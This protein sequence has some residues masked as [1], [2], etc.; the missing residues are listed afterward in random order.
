MLAVNGRIL[1]APNM[2]YSGNRTVEPRF[3]SWNM[4]SVK[5]SKG[6]TLTAWSVLWLQSQ[7]GRDPWG[8]DP[9][10]LL[11]TLKAFHQRL[12]DCGMQCSPPFLPGVNV[13]V[14]SRNDQLAIEEGF[15]RL[16]SKKRQEKLLLIIMP[17][18]NDDHYNTI[19]RCG[20]LEF[21]VQT[22]CVLASKFAKPNNS[23][24]FANVALKFNL[25][26]G[27]IN[28]TLPTDKLGFIAQG[29]TIVV[30]ID[31]THP[32]P[33]SESSAPSVASMVA[34]INKDLGQFPA[35]LYTQRGRQE[36]VA[37]LSIMLKTRL[38]LWRK[39]NGDRLPENILVYRDGVSEGQ[40]PAVLA[41]ELP[42][43]QQA[44]REI[45][46]A[47]SKQPAISIVIVSKRHSTRFYIT[48][49]DGNKIDER[50]SNPKHGTIVDRG[51]TEPRF[52][53]F[54]LQAHTALQGTARPA[55]Y[56]VV[57][58]EILSRMPLPHGF[59]HAADVLEDV[60]HNLSYM[61]GRATKAVSYCPAAYYADI[62][63][64]RGRCYL[65]HLFS[66]TMSEADVAESP[67]GQAGGADRGQL[68]RVHENLKDTM[69][70][71]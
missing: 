65:S 68:I 64:E 27:G 7:S 55:H 37:D 38:A 48:T 61:F 31:V 66:P 14:D 32:S 19:K 34:S 10:Q 53:D 44:C 3:G 47:N 36:M 39:H 4:G 42:L 57:H 16:L 22:V 67:T 5:F 11:P 43:L 54:Y 71:I 51:I 15:Q 60:T 1:P 49:T 59:T 70:Y 33:G 45:Y 24:Y 25:K 26:L 9:K 58:D 29:K 62:A 21:G 52:W 50:S 6:S 30:G 2:S 20:D 13:S 28:Q 8:G 41:E 46:P 18:H 17:H 56:F 12:L 63:C 23:Q 69:F 35:V 40:Y